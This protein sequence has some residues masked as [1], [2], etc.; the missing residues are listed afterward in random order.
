MK[1]LKIILIVLGSIAALAGGAI[2]VGALVLGWAFGTQRDADG[3]FTTPT[4]RFSSDARAITSEDADVLIDQDAADWLPSDLAEIRLRAEGV[5]GPVFIGIGPEDEVQAYLAGVS[6][7]VVRDVS[8]GRRFDIEYGD[9]P[10]DAVPPPPG[11]QDFWVA[12]A[13]GDGVQTLDW[14]LENGRWTVVL[15]NADGSPGVAAELS[16]GGRSSLLP[17]AI[18][19]LLVLGLFFIAGGAGLILLGALGVRGSASG[20][21]A[22]GGAPEGALAIEGAEPVRIVGHLDPSLSRWLWLVKWFLAIPHYV[23]LFFLWIAFSVLTFFAGVAILFT[24]RYPRGI[25]DFNVGVLRWTWRVGFYSTSAIGTD[26]YP[27]FSLGPEPDYP[28]TLEV[29]YP[30]HLSRGLVLVKW[31]LLAIP[32]Y[33]ILAILTS[34]PSWAIDNNDRWQA[35]GPSLLTIAVLIAGLALLVRGRYPQGLFNL[36]MGVNRWIFRVVVYAALMTDDY[37]P[38]R[39]DQGSEEPRPAGPPSGGAAPATT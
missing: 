23:V 5:S 20:A 7:S 18:F 38:F 29:D 2:L 17:A 28:A 31:W 34:S 25:F 33:I 13:S 27:P 39:L 36:L 37:P 6:R 12:Q 14:S 3:Y 26:E 10:G 19:I 16:A 9:I 22:T 21:T 24:G 32:H 8:Y 1:P 4:E 35:S 15:M 11:T 30:E